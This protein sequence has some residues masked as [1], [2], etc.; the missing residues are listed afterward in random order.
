ML[1]CIFS[2]FLL[3]RIISAIFK[4]LL[5]DIKTAISGL[6]IIDSIIIDESPV[7]KFQMM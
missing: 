4:D 5:L 3:L 6:V 1:L 2:D 7:Q